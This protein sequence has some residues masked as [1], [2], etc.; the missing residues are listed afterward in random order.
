[1][2][3][4]PQTGVISKDLSGWYRFV[5]AGA[6]RAARL[7][8]IG[9]ESPHRAGVLERHAPVIRQPTLDLT[10]VLAQERHVERSIRT[11]KG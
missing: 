8:L 4:S 1:M 7:A 10:A 6:Q 9:R 3:P 5:P 11:R 2:S